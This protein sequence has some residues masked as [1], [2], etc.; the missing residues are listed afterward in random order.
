MTKKG[1]QTGGMEK[2]PQRKNREAQRRRRQEAGWA[3]KAGPVTVR[4]IGDPKPAPGED[5]E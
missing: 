1:A 5:T 4:H 3:A 2:S